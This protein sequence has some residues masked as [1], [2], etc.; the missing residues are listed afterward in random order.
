MITTDT[1]VTVSNIDSCF[2]RKVV[3]ELNESH[4]ITHV[5][6]AVCCVRFI[7]DMCGM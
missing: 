2:F 1:K 5:T 7:F 6:F 3:S 4:Q